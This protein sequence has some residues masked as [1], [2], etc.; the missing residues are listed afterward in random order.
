MR[1]F[2]PKAKFIFLTLSVLLAFLSFPAGA[3]KKKNDSD[4][5][6][7]K[8]LR[9]L[10]WNIQDG[11]WADQANNYDNFVEWVKQY[12]PDICVF[13]EAST[14]YATGTREEIPL[15]QRY[16]P[17]H[18]GELCARW[19]HTSWEKGPQRKSSGYKYGIC[20]YPQVVTSRFPIECIARFVAQGACTRHR[21]GI[22]YC[23]SACLC[24]Q[25]WSWH[26][27]RDYT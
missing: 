7:K 8:T 25:I 5:A 6:Q 20:N 1:C 27:G 10:Y 18:W 15:D 17:D 24:F 22:Q 21:E 9:I 16:L 14:I 12:D 13:C 4:P 19:G 26:Q 3:Q 11:M 2:E 23:P